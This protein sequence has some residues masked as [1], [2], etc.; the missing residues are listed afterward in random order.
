MK[1]PHAVHMARLR[2]KSLT[3][4]RRSEI[5]RIANSA[6]QKKRQDAAKEAQIAQH[7]TLTTIQ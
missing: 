6:R 2:A 3:P 1:N 7:Q 4:E 5:A